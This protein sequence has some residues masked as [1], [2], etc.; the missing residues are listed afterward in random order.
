[1]ILDPA[2]IPCIIKQANYIL[3]ISV[4]DNNKLQLKILKEICSE[5]YRAADNLSAPYFSARTQAIIGK[6]R[7]TENI[8]RLIKENNLRKIK[9]YRLFVRTMIEK[10][11]DRLETAVR[12]A[13][14]GNAFDLGANPGFDIEY[15]INR[16]SSS[17]YHLPALTKF[18]SDLRKA[19]LILYIGD[20]YEEALFDKY[21]LEELSYI[22][23]VFAV[24]SR[25][26][27]N[28]IT[29]EDAVRLKLHKICRVIESGSSI[30]GTDLREC[31]PE[32]LNLFR[33]ADI[34][35][36]KGQGNY[37]TLADEKRPVY[38]LFKIKCNTVERRT[39][40]QKGKGVFLYN[41]ERISKS[42]KVN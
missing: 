38:F 16:I 4:K 22:N 18:K 39:G 36:A 32:F 21:L 7:N 27:L 35:I 30:P 25:P 28:D 37:E 24:R 34:V 31:T 26:V 42:I 33:N 13:I 12:A 10:S 9:K 8:Y 1:M 6:Y 17:E 15:E 19:K 5:I 2:C 11:D 14:A 23:T 29:Y 40:F 20:N 3:N 41:P